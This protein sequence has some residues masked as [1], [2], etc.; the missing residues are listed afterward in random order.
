MTNRLCYDYDVLSDQF[1]AI[2]TMSN[3]LNI[4]QHLQQMRHLIQN[5]MQKQNLNTA[6][7]AEALQIDRKQLKRLLNGTQELGSQSAAS[8]FCDCTA[9]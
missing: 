1:I 8:K 7:V 3:D 9:T 6:A 2:H 4:D 5:A